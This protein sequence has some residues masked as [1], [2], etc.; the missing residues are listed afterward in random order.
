MTTLSGIISKI[1]IAVSVPFLIVETA[2]AAAL[3]TT[4]IEGAPSLRNGPSE[5]TVVMP[6][7]RLADTLPVV[8]SEYEPPDDING[9]NSS[10]GSGTR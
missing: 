10:E 7:V 3:V 1:A 8:L 5:S 2:S 6:T 9:P 4:G